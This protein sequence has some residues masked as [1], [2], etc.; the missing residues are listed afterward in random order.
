MTQAEIMGLTSTESQ[1]RFEEILV[2]FRDSL[3]D[4]AS[5]NNGEVREDKDD[6]ETEQ[7]KLGEDDEPCWV[8][9]TITKTVQNSME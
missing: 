9:G 8:M 1:K 2:A 6:E 3:R 7:G 5:S 4:L